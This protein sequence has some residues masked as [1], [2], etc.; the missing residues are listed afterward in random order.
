VRQLGGTAHW[1]EYELEGHGRDAG[2]GM[3]ILFAERA[4]QGSLPVALASCLAKYT[5]ETCMAGFN[6][7]WCE[8]QPGLKPTAGY[9]TDGRRWV[10]EA[11]SALVRA[12][13]PDDVL[14]RRR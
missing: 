4:E 9:T 13:L 7:Y 10:A 14:V 5:R 1:S 11:E 6:A 8:R 12:A 2:R 3:R